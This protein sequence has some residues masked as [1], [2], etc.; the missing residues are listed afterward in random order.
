MFF[1]N[2]FSAFVQNLNFLCSVESRRVYIESLLGPYM[3]GEVTSLVMGLVFGGGGSLSRSFLEVVKIAGVS[4][5][6]SA[7]GSNVSL[8]LLITSGIFRKRFGI[9]FTAIAGVLGVVAYLAVSGC[10]S[11]LLRAS[12]TAVLTL[13]GTSLW[14]RKPHQGW[15]LAITCA[16][17]IFISA[18]YLTDLSFQLSVAACIGILLGPELFPEKKEK[19]L[20]DSIKEL[21]HIYC[22]SH[23]RSASFSR[24]N[25]QFGEKTKY[26]RT[27]IVATLRTTLAVQY[28]T[29]PIIVFHFHELSILGVV[30]NVLLIW[31]VP[32]IIFAG[33]ATIV[34][35]FLNIS[36]C[37]Y[38]FGQLTEILSN[39]FMQVV[40]IVGSNNTF[41]FEFSL[42]QS[43]SI[44][45]IY[46][47][48]FLILLAWFLTKNSHSRKN[49]LLCNG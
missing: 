48:S 21:K 11:P 25:R 4:H 17:M 14:K 10:S 19:K 38:F 23:M 12:L 39:F 47:V 9:I 7:S 44:L 18:D 31:V 16:V 33:I 29:L 30:S 26:L 2:A 42:S 49:H 41:F 36:L 46:F 28:L 22:Q 27:W 43:R 8:V 40:R 35:S 32:W 45:T 3:T 20:D 6:L 5:V 1:H 34:F 15:I 13:L 37:A 24:V